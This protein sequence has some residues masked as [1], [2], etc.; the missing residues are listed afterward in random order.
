MYNDRAEG[1][2]HVRSLIVGTMIVL[3]HTLLLD[4][5]EGGGNRV[6]VYLGELE[7]VYYQGRAGVGLDFWICEH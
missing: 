1:V 2:E 4:T 5:I 6:R 7:K 3:S